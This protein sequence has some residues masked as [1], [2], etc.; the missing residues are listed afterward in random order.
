[1]INKLASNHNQ[2]LFIEL[3]GLLHDIGK[4][5][6]AFLEYRRKWQDDP[7][8]WDKDPH[9]HDY[10]DKHELFSDLLPSS[11]ET[12]IKD[13]GGC[14]FCEP[15]FSIRKAVHAHVSP[16]SNALINLMLKA[17]D[18][19]D[20]A[21]DR[22]NPLWSAEQKDKIFKS[23]VFGYESGRV[24]DFETQEKARQELYNFLNQNKNLSDYLSKFA[25]K[26]RKDILSKIKK[27]FEQGLSDTTRPQNDTTLWEH[28]YAVASIL[29]VLAVH[30]LLCGEILDKPDKVRFGILGIGWDGVRFISYGQ[31]IGD[32]IGRKKIIEDVKTGLKE[33][34]EYKYPIGN[35]I[36]AD[37]DGIY[38]IVPAKLEGYDGWK[39][40]EQEIYY[41]ASDV[42]CGELQPSVHIESETRYMTRLVKVIADLRKKAAFQF[43]SEKHFDLFRQ[44]IT[45]H[46]NNTADKTIC[47]ICRL[48]PVEKEDE[49]KKVCE[50]CKER[51]SPMDDREIDNPKNKETVFIDEIVDRNK[52]AALIAARFGLHDWF[53][54]DMVR[55]VFVT[56]VNGIEREI[57]SLELGS[58]KQFADGDKKLSKY[59]KDKTY[60]YQRIKEDID[61]FSNGND[62]RARQTAFLYDRRP[63]HDPDLG[64]IRE[65]WSGLCES[66]CKERG[67]SSDDECLLY[68]ILC[69][70]TP[71]PSTVLD[72][73]ETTQEF[74]EGMQNV[75]LRSIFPESTRLAL[76]V[77]R[78]NGRD[79]YGWGK[80]TLEAKIEERGQ[81]I[82]LLY[83]DDGKV[84][85]VGEKYPESMS[86]GEWCDVKWKGKTIRITQ[87]DSDLYNST[88]EITGCYPG[89]NYYP[90]RTITT[91]PNLFMAIV[92]ADRAV[93]ISAL[94]YEKY[95]EQFGKGMGRLPFSI[96]NTF[97][98]HKMPMFVVL[99]A[100]R[101]MIGNFDT[102][103][104][105]PV[106]NNFTIKDKTKSS[107]DYRFGLECS[108][109]GLKRSFTWRLPH[110]LGNCADDYHHP[111]FII[112][113]EKDRYSN[114][115]TFFETIAGS[116]VHFTEIKE[117]DVLSVYPNYYDFE[118]LD[119]NARRHDIVLD[120]PGRRRSNVADFKSKPFLLDE[121]GQKVMCLWKELLQGRQLQ[122]ITDTKL[123]KLQSLWLTKYQEWVI[124][125]NEEGFKAWENLVW[126]SLDKEFAL[127]KEQ[128]ELLEKTIESGLFFDTL[129][130]YLG[131]LKERIDKK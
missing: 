85:I 64:K 30:Y 45:D 24:V 111:Y 127:S 72:V 92:P 60:N 99:D 25:F 42:S 50:I 59:F 13:L 114:R 8:G 106:C 116:V 52:R 43:D 31:K 100:G 32:I 7:N 108:L 81:A 87:K 66:E 35:E 57:T 39:T 10:L 23:N 89:Y 5:S 118:F 44:F 4:L 67:A 71:T 9:D 93:E 61:S 48:R 121:L 91:S 74:F 128:R 18:G 47:P 29:K 1:M 96:G 3:A 27:A 103:A 107:A 17:A 51:R 16:S 123:R 53:N 122:G 26:K 54:G 90:Y 120:E 37:D 131:I 36:Y 130:L 115:S 95:V 62:E 77:R 129:E 19:V 21:I 125:R 55:T 58:V 11:F 20:A 117:G 98:A 126:V 73:W 46:W 12:S 86:D 109:D 40:V 76:T 70:K 97:F 22:N 80:G 119:S 69:A 33:L 101:R 34:I 56:E 83:R 49:K 84:E 78:I 15:D 82:E 65:R 79:I 68:N 124:D 110:K 14:D 105:K 2:I 63:G 75:L 94:V 113:G 41:L 88:H 102:L 112:D 6:K 38:F 28:S 104:K